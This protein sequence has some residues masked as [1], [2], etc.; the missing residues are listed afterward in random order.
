MVLIF[1]TDEVLNKCDYFLAL[2]FVVPQY[3]FISFLALLL[4]LLPHLTDLFHQLT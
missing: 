1:D 2:C 4:A 3:S